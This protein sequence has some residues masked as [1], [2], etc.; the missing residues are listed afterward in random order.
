M[1]AAQ[2]SM[3]VYY[4]VTA[5]IMVKVVWDDVSGR[6]AVLSIFS[7]AWLVVVPALVLWHAG[8]WSIP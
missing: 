4:V 2:Y 3:M 7:I 5:P 6:E 1:T 8:F